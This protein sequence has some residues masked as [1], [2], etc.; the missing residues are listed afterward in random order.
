ML[1]LAVEP[2]EEKWTDLADGKDYTVDYN[3]VTY[4][5]RWDG[6]RNTVK[7]S[8]IA[9]YVYN[10]YVRA[11]YQQLTGLGVGAQHMENAEIVSPNQK[12]IWS[13]NECARLSSDMQLTSPSLFNFLSNAVDVDDVPIYTNWLYTP[14]AEMN[15]FDV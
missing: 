15:M 10:R 13:N 1:G 8:L 12:L 5:V 14:I 2:V 6:L 4:N 7:E 3:D 11:N 9:Y